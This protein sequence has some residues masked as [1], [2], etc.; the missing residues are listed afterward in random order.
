VRVAREQRDLSA[1]RSS[2]GARYAVIGQVQASGSTVLILA[3]L[4][5]LSDLTHVWV[6]RV[7]GDLSD[8]LELR[9]RVASE[10]AIQFA[11][12]MRKDPDRAASFA[13]PTR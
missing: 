11:D 5:R 1:I 8:P 2:L 4:I 10:I 7:K 12:R 13:S 9:S 3:H 6:V